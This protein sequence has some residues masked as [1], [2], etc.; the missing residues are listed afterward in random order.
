MILK[1]SCLFDVQL[2]G[3]KIKKR[4]NQKILFSKTVDI[5]NFFLIFNTNTSDALCIYTKNRRGMLN[6]NM[7]NQKSCKW[8]L[9]T[10]TIRTQ[11]FCQVKNSNDQITEGVGM[12][13]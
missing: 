1:M 10:G 4:K 9:F 11:G 2:N 5:N 13:I 8:C 12:C 3:L 7:T 6:A